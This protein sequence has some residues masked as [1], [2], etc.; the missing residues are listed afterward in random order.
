[1][2][3]KL[4]EIVA[5]WKCYKWWWNGFIFTRSRICKI[6]APP[7]IIKWIMS[8]FQHATHKVYTLYITS[9]LP[10]YL[11]GQRIYYFTLVHKSVGIKST[12]LCGF[13]CKVCQHFLQCSIV[14]KWLRKQRSC[15][16]NIDICF[17]CFVNLCPLFVFFFCLFVF[18]SFLV[19]AL[20]PW[21]SS[22]SFFFKI[23][24]IIL[25]WSSHPIILQG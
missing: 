5:S 16:V 22:F 13:Q 14:H 25:I 2:L 17:C 23:F 3:R 18:L 19:F 20:F 7:D 9:F 1:M 12:I 11:S 21:V 8:L 24:I 4:V 15:L 6:C 10:K